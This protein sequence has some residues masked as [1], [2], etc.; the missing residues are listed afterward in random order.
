MSLVPKFG[1]PGGKSFAGEV[2]CLIDWRVSVR[3]DCKVGFLGTAGTAGMV[4][5][6]L[7][8]TGLMALAG[9]SAGLL[10]IGEPS[11]VCCICH[12]GHFDRSLSLSKSLSDACDDER[13]SRSAVALSGSVTESLTAHIEA[14]QRCGEHFASYK[15]RM[16]LA[17]REL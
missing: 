9:A 4:R 12:F 16:N 17:L 11:L 2:F 5:T 6:L 1:I 8:C 14:G 10:G 15:H 3:G 13:A 7:N